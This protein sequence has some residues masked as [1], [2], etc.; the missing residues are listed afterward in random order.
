M[1]GAKIQTLFCKFSVKIARA[2][3]ENQRL[4]TK[5]GK[6]T[7]IYRMSLYGNGL[8]EEKPVLRKI[9]WKS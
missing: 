8:S 4:A 9:Q 6:I 5:A 1:Q 2:R 3:T 7:K